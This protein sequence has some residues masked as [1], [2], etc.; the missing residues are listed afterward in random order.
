MKNKGTSLSILLLSDTHGF[1]DDDILKYARDADEVWHAGD[2]GDLT[3]ID[4][5]KKI[6]PLYMVHGNIDS[7]II[8]REVPAEQ[9]FER[10]GVKIFIIHIGGYAGRIPKSL[11]E[12][13]NSRPTDLL[14]CGHSHILRAGHEPSG[15]LCLNPGAAGH[16]GFHRTRT[17]MRF[18]I[19][20]NKV[21]NLS[22]IELGK[23]G[24]F[25]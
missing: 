3:V 1:I 11:R 24:V 19:S 13:I 2:I 9:Y 8:R 5:L 14:I 16:H 18:E 4:S 6:K 23:R 17:M 15:L 12:K 20:D 10:L 21:K 22:V 25:T 7:G